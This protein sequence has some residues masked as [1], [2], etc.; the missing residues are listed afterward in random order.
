MAE[1]PR[2]P[3]AQ[4]AEYLKDHKIEE[5]VQGLI[6]ELL[7]VKPPESR[8]FLLE[9]LERIKQAGARP[10]L[11]AADLRAMFDM[12]DV[13]GSGVVTAAQANAAL[14]TALGGARAAEAAEGAAPGGKGGGG[15]GAGGGA[16][17]GGLLVAK[18]AAARR[19]SKEEFVRSVGDALL[20]ATPNCQ[21]AVPQVGG[22]GDDCDDGTD[23]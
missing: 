16:A 4:V 7:F 20:R 14:A 23:G 10:L 22:D 13:T 3:R 15:G 1:P 18:G 5:I 11:D 19:L 2:D 17:A 21:L 12:F 9:Q 6:A 8:A